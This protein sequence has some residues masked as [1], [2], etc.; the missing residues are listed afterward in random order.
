MT[1]E[2]GSGPKKRYALVGT[3]S[4]SNM[5]ISALLESHSD[6]GEL[7]ALCDT[8]QTRM[9]YYSR[10]AETTTGRPLPTYRHTDFDTMITEAK[11]DT[12]IVTTIDRAHH[13][14][15]VR[16]MELGCDVIT[17]KPM[18]IDA[19]RCQTIIDAV[20]RTGRDLKVTFNYRYAPRN[21]KVKEL[22]QAGEIGEVFSVHFEWLLDTQHGA[23]YFR[24]W[25]RDKRNSGGLMVHKATHHFDLVNWWLKSAPQTVFAMG[26]LRFY[27]RE[28]AERRGVETLYS[29]AHGSEAAKRDPFAI[30]MSANPELRAL[31]LEA[32]HE[33][34]YHRDQSVFA[35][36]ISIEDT[37]AV[38][39]RYQNRALLSYSLNAYC[40]WEGYRV[41][42]NGSQGRLEVEV[43]ERSY[44]SGSRGDHNTPGQ[45][46]LDVDPSRS[47]EPLKATR[48]RLQKQWQQ[49]QD[50]PFE[51]G[52]GGHGGGDERLLNDI[53]RGSSHDPLNR[54][55]GYQDGARSI[56]VGIAANQAFATGQPVQID[57]LVRL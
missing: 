1:R 34:G 25:H 33:D 45:R 24:R 10:K 13:H 36:G 39:V 16:A 35:D 4:R 31:Y 20:R 26:D 5:Y 57:D 11:P 6:V 2:T 44:V 52:Q 23:D 22:L 14:Y 43:A 38:L 9:A 3:G 21:S 27:G 42:F 7:V 54:A 19:E 18:T 49:A 32:E 55:A 12:V 8:N 51:S 28:N 41:M 40:P 37:M 56:L 46:H 15:I 30:D 47:E 29:R 48:I 17:E 50:V 53:F